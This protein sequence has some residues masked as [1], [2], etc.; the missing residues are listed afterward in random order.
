LNFSIAA[1]A[2]KHTIDGDINLSSMEEI[3]AIMH[4]D[5]SGRLKR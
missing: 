2:L 5:T 4:G 3:E 1:S